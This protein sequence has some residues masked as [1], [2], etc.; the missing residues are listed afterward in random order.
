MGEKAKKR[1]WASRARY[2]LRLV[3]ELGVADDSLETCGVGCVLCWLAWMRD[4]RTGRGEG[5][6]LR[7]GGEGEER[8]GGGGE[9]AFETSPGEEG[10]KD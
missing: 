3:R 10:A 5:K 4:E 7:C 2:C 1:V 8:R 6:N 9:E